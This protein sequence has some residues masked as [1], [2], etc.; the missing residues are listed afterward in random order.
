MVC[1]FCDNYT[2]PVKFRLV[3]KWQCSSGVLDAMLLG[4]CNDP[5]INYTPGDVKADM[6]RE[7]GIRLSYRQAWRGRQKAF[8]IGSQPCR[9]QNCLY[10]CICWR[11]HM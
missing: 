4:K 8:N 10:I 11:K 2:C 7:H 1:K 9:I 5:K 6:K 3:S